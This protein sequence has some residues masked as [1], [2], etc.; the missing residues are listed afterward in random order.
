MEF[1]RSRS[2]RSGQ[3]HTLGVDARLLFAINQSFNIDCIQVMSWSYFQD[4]N[5]T[6]RVFVGPYKSSIAV[7][8]K[9]D[10]WPPFLA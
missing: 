2:P 3:G 4:L 8:L 10:P 6:F 1:R 5:R 7:I 9:A